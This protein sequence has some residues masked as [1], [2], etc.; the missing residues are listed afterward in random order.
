M[1][2]DGKPKL[3][4]F[5]TARKT[6]YSVR[7]LITR[8]NNNSRKG[9]ARYTAYEL[10]SF[11]DPSDENAEDDDT[12]SEVKCSPESDMWSFGMVIYVSIIS[13]SY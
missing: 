8:P 7:V 9:T 5:G 2:N 12:E 10:L 6:E 13:S 3:I 11:C 4:D 1:G